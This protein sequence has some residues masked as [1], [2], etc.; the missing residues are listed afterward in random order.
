MKTR[1][2]TRPAKL[3]HRN[4]PYKRLLLFYLFLWPAIILSQPKVN[5]KHYTTEDGLSQSYIFCMLQDRHGFMWFGTEDGLNKF[6]GYRFTVFRNIS[7]DTTSLS[8][9]NIRAVYEDQE[10]NI[11]AGTQTGEL[12]RFDRKTETFFCYTLDKA[13]KF[14]QPQKIITAISQDLNGTLWV[15]TIGAG[16][17]YLKPGEKSF[18]FFLHHPRESNILSHN[19][20]NS[21]VVD[22]K[23]SLWVGTPVGL[24][25]RDH[26]SQHFVHYQ[27]NAAHSKGLRN[28]TI[29]ALSLGSFGKLWIGTSRGI[30]WYDT[31]LDQW[32]NFGEG[33]SASCR[34]DTVQVIALREDLERNLWVATPHGLLKI[35]PKAPCF[36]RFVHSETDPTSI[37]GTRFFGIEVDQEGGVWI[38]TRSGVNRYD[39]K[40]HRFRHYTHEPGNPRSLPNKSVWYFRQDR[41]GLFW[42]STEAGHVP[43]DLQK[44][45]IPASELD[46]LFVEH[47]VKQ[48]RLFLLEDRQGNI[49]TGING[50]FAINRN[51]G[52]VRQ[53]FHD[54]S[55]SNSLGN[56]AVWRIYESRDSLIWI[57]RWGGLSV[58]YPRTGSFEN[59]H[60]D[61]PDSSGF[62][63]SSPTDFFE[64]R[65]GNMWIGTRSGGLIRFDRDDKIFYHFQHDPNDTTSISDNVIHVIQED[66]LGRLWIS[67][68]SGLN[69]MLDKQKG[70]FKRIQEKD[71]LPNNYVFGI[72]EDSKHRLWMS[73]IKGIFCYDPEKETFKTYNAQDGLSGNG[74]NDDSYFMDPR[75]GEMFFGGGN[76]FTVFHPDSIR[77]DTFIPPVVISRFQILVQGKEG[78]VFSEQK[79]ISEKSEIT[80]T[81]KQK[82]LLLFEF[83]SLSFSKPEKN[84]YQYQLSGYSEDWILLGTRKEVSFTNLA[85]GN[86]ILRVKGSNGDGIWNEIPAELKIKILPPWYWSWWTKSIYL[87]LTIGGIY[88]F[89]RFQLNRRLSQA[90]A[91]RLR[92]LDEFKT[93][94]YT[95]ITHEFRTPLTIIIG[96][97]ETIEQAP[98]EW[99]KDGLK[100]IKRNGHNLLRLV[101]QLLDLSRLEAGALPLKIVQGDIVAF[102]RTLLELFHSYAESK[103]IEM[104]FESE[105]K[106]I[107]MDYDPD[108]TK[109]IVSNLIS[110]AIKF[111]PE[112]GKISLK[113]E[114][115]ENAQLLITVKDTG[116]GIPPEKLPLI[117]DRFYQ[118]DDSATRKGE[119]TGIGMALTQELVKL[120]KGK[121]EVASEVGKGSVFSV[122]LPIK[123]TA[124]LSDGFP[125]VAPLMPEIHPSFENSAKQ[126]SGELP[127]ALIV[128]DNADVITYL[129]ACLKSQYRLEVA[130]NGQ[131]GID[132]AIELVP[133]VIVSDVMMPEKDGFELC[134][135]LKSDMRT[136]HIPIVLLTALGDTSSRLEGLETG[137]DAYLAKP[138]NERELEISLRKSMELRQRLRERF[139]SGVAQQDATTTIYSK[140]DVFIADLH[141]LLEQTYTNPSF[142]IPLM[143]K[144]MGVSE[145]QLRRKV[146]AL[147]DTTPQLYF[148]RF[149]LQKAY[150]LVKDSDLRINEIAF[151]T[152]F[153][154][155][156]HFSNVFLEEFGLRPSNFR[157]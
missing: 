105:Q 60:N 29:T 69:L 38:G 124:P 4:P 74:F 92:E 93:R 44:G 67:T 49:W 10:G 77:D 157:R 34:L 11:W 16:L 7:G 22:Q 125:Q 26:T 3:N 59:Y 82:V 9:N 122:W 98:R 35:E 85:P 36:R 151:A 80:L 134:R 42:I 144:G 48:K 127:L 14:S 87:I 70:G 81:H 65:E 37:N 111:T 102:L 79:G 23:G 68:A 52:H 142:T 104:R 123:N 139:A 63:F 89:Y 71:G 12:N 150:H 114:I 24:F 140:E 120:F 147:L 90:E 109:D 17:Y 156:V 8:Y 112:N 113:V 100:M 41:N 6:D 55:N 149:R 152:G 13:K 153:D 32:H 137:A 108:K 46:P 86:Y 94:F 2:D 58:L 121:I 129:I 130:Y 119:G 45:T 75:T 133:D 18:Q 95:N 78:A 107:L 28:D 128:E 61:P 115:A 33:L 50:L 27:S 138:F 106:Q 83:A 57:K 64:D 56:N 76:G 136:S 103:K 126:A 53:Y 21:I 132:K 72:L 117:F 15:G 135:T 43:F 99:L 31:N 73:S 5:F 101:N 116:V 20:I 54:P 84:Q 39:A 51:S 145:T 110:N 118:V 154:D 131:S 97:A 1:F 91:V 62:G 148:R 30:E 155:P 47:I 88:T 141:K 143:A 96:M 19:V 146:Q 40:L 25:K 66:H